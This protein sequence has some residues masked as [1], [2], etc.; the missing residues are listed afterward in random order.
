MKI[1]LND[2]CGVSQYAKLKGVSTVTVQNHITVGK[3]E[4]IS[5][6]GR[7]LIYIGDIE[8]SDRVNCLDKNRCHG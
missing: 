3:L 7:K 4:T 2:Y 8:M 5:H 1:E 6:W